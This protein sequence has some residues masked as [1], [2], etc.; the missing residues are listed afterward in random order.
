MFKYIH[1]YSL[2]I[3]LC[4][5]YTPKGVKVCLLHQNSSCQIFA[6]DY[7]YINLFLLIL[8]KRTLD[9]ILYRLND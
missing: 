5:K 7:D 1:A 3:K 4:I 2:Y 9:N 8:D 6:T